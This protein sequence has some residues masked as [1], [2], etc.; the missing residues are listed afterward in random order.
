[1]IRVAIIGGYGNFG[2]YVARTLADQTNIQLIIAGRR[3]AKARSFA[4]SLGAHNPAEGATYDLNGP[5]EALASLK[6]DLVI[7]MVG[8]YNDQGYGVAE[9]AIACGAH[10]CDISDAREFVAG[11]GTLDQAA[12]KARKAGVAVLSGASS[13]PALTAAYLDEAV[14]DGITI[15]AAS[16]GISGAEQ[17]N[18]GV[19]TVSAVLRYVG[20][21]FTT[22][23]GGEMRDVRGW[24]DLHKVAI[25]GL[26]KRWFGRGNVPDLALF[27]GRYPSLQDHTFWA[28]HEI[29]LLHFGTAA[30][31]WL[32]HKGLLPRLDRIAPALV[33]LSTLFNWMGKGRSGF[34]L[35]IDGTHEN[36]TAHLRRHYI[37]ARQ[38]H[39]P[40]IPCIPVILIAK[41]MA[42]GRVIEAGARPCL[43]VI[44]L[45]DYHAGFEGLDVEVIDA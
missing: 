37:I 33:R 26:G 17:A 28:G 45:A 10:Y 7:N 20:Q 38:G 24:S 42:A 14:K 23:Q 16:Y 15:H 30:M 25:P 9:A 13:V 6:P 1:M 5:P 31:G 27:K 3:A 39:G 8:P 41:Q 29:P 12:R 21:T 32:A 40:Y 2:G 35:Y 44:S 43:G 22:L 4:A 36:G 34:Y 11:I 18:R 19:G